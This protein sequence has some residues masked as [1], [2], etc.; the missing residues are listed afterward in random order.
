MAH[1]QLYLLV[2]FNYGVCRG[3]GGGRVNGAPA[4]IFTSFFF[5]YGV[6]RGGGGG[7]SLFNLFSLIRIKQKC[8]PQFSSHQASTCDST[9]A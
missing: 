9:V 3:G 2:F 7:G 5:N 8:D 4:A 6:C 1:Q